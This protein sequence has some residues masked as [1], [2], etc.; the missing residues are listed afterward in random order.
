MLHTS[1]IYPNTY[2]IYIY[3]CVCKYAAY[4]I[5]ITYYILHITYYILYIIYCIFY[6]ILYCFILYY[7]I[8]CIILYYIL[9]IILYTTFITVFVK[10]NPCIINQ[11]SLF[12]RVD[13][14][15][16]SRFACVCVCLGEF[17]FPNA[18]NYPFPN[19]SY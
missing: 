6:I 5:Y 10:D 8:F 16:Q 7:I 12:I 3:I 19:K 11:Y 17:M 15:Q 14:N 4:L 13:I 2:I 18:I 9:Y 1:H